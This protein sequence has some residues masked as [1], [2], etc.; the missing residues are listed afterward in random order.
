MSSISFNPFRRVSESVPDDRTQATQQTGQDN[1]PAGAGWN[2]EAG[3]VSFSADR[4]AQA[5]AYSRTGQATAGGRAVRA[6]WKSPIPAMLDNDDYGKVIGEP[7]LSDKA[8]EYYKQLKSKF[9]NLDFV[10]VGKDSIQAAKAHANSYGN[11]S[12]MVVLIDEEKLERMATDENFRKKYEAII[13]QAQNGGSRLSQL[14]AQNPNIMKVG[15]NN[16]GD[17]RGTFVAAC[18]K[19]TSD[20]SAR[21]AEKRAARKA[22]AKAAEKKAHKKHDEEV[23]LERREKRHAE[24]DDLRE[25]IAERRNRTVIDERDFSEYENNDDYELIY[26]DS[27]E[28]LITKLEEYNAKFGYG[29]AE[30]DAGAVE[31]GAEAGAGATATAVGAGA[32]AGVQVGQ[33]MNYQA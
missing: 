19:G 27:M 10:L 8:A 14:A 18:L 28:E 4:Y 16:S 2:S 20:I 1:K 25:K 11:A 5:D 21:M 22:E 12:H 31:A 32:G 3:A 6:G 24:E 7:K 30:A 26:A 29:V 23:R 9:G 13:S 17:G 33:Y 15:I